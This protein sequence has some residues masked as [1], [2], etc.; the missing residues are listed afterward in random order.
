MSNNKPFNIFDKPVPTTES[1]LHSWSDISAA[2]IADLKIQVARGLGHVQPADDAPDEL[3]NAVGEFG[4]ATNPI[5]C[6]SVPACIAYLSKLRTIE[7]R[8]I[9]YMRKNCL[10]KKTVSEYPLD[11]YLI[12]GTDGKPL[13]T[14][15]M[16]GYQRSD[17]KVAPEGFTLDR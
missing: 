3:A 7:G 4:S 2:E 6:S 17:S 15:Y 10:V 5:G 12:L 8:S 14:I 16:S 9:Q 11:A 1:I 13:T